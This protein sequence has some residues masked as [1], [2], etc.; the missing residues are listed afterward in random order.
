MLNLSK[1]ITLNKN[2]EDITVSS[3]IAATIGMII[4]EILSNTIK[5]AFPDSKKGTI[6]IELKKI[7]SQMVLIVEDNG[8]GLQKDFDINKIKSIGLHLVNLMVTQ[9]DGKIKFISENGTKI[10]IEFLLN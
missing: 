2:L 8:I 7:N 3:T 1:N 9:L 10:I 4:V 5:Y 6:S